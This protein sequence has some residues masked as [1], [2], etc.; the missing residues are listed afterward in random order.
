MKL[1]LKAIAVVALVCL[2]HLSYSQA[3]KKFHFKTL[4]VDTHNDI[5][6]ECFD[7]HLSFDDNLLGKT[8]S[9]LARFKQGGVDVQ[10][11]S[12]WCDG[13]MKEPYNYANAQIDTL[14]AT[15]KRN[16]SAVALV[17]SSAE[18]EKA[19]KDKKLAAMIGVEGGHMIENDLS[20]LDNLYKR[21]V[22]YM[23]L[24]WNNSNPWATSAMF[25]TSDSTNAPKGLT[26][27]GKEV[28]KKMNALGMMI[29]ISHV[30]EK[31]F[32]DVIAATTKP[33]I[34]SHSSAY[35]LAPVFRNLKDD[36]IKA[37]TKN[38]GV[39]HVNFYSGF[40]DS[41]FLRKDQAFQVRHK[42]ERDS[43]LK[44]NPEPH[45]AGASLFK[46]YASEV[47]DMKAP[48]S[49]LIDHI[50]QIVKIAGIDHVGLGSDFD[51]IESTPKGLFDVT[52]YPLITAALLQRGYSKKDVRK[53]L[54]LNFLRV[55]KANEE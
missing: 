1:V 36:Q 34:A 20:K 4:V 15:I 32:Y 12:I 17:T 30:G 29:D 24:T 21:G 33:V 7:K 31:T 27:F 18:L 3:N 45:F 39:I 28:V 52:T 42:V 41:N 13:E 25:E 54:G 44:I 48:L 50:D 55:L 43:L 51:G 49:L 8:H 6:T 46:K 40:L 37:V 5:L 26:D 22:R 19:V 9:D 11:F 10:I 2:S 23:T 35:A 38:G 53:I 47:E 14:Y 16:P